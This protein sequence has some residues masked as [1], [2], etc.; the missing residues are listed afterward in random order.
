MKKFD[1]WLLATDLDGTLYTKEKHIPK[2]NLEAIRYFIDEGGLFTVATGRPI[3]STK[4]LIEGVPLSCPAI[5]CNGQAIYDFQSDGMVKS[6]YY[7]ESV[8]DVISFIMELFPTVGVELF[9]DLDDYIIREN[10]YTVFH[11]HLEKFLHHSKLD[12][13]P[14][15]N[16]CKIIFSDAPEVIDELLCFVKDKTYS[17]FSF[18]R[19]DPRYAEFQIDGT[20][21]GIALL[22]L[23]EIYNIP[24]RQ[25]CGIG[26]YYNDAPLINSAG[27]GAL[28]C[29]AP[30]EMKA[31]ADYIT[32]ADCESG[33]LA[34]FIEYIEIIS[35]KTV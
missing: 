3:C 11:Y 18:I 6:H 24:H 20:G 28:V 13:V 23:G 9:C 5:T 26:N 27:I 33:A 30:E 17:G 4:K 19:T 29:D 31:S 14:R 21:K 12:E 15:D 10:P 1:K 7:P 25:I 35:N 8:F 32:K 22:E 34:E 16:I 2:R